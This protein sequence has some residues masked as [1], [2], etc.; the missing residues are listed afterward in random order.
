MQVKD[1]SACLNV[2]QKNAEEPGVVKLLKM[3]QV[4]SL[5]EQ[6]GKGSRA[7]G[8][9]LAMP[10]TIGLT[11]EDFQTEGPHQQW[12]SRCRKYQRLIS[13][14]FSNTTNCARLKEYICI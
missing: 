7:R 3:A 1:N 4:R 13:S 5:P 2:E 10:V 9:M 12:H 8:G 14:T 6:E 11:S